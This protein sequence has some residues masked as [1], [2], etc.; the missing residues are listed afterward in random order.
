M[1]S[2]LEHIDDVGN[3]ARV[4]LSEIVDAY[5]NTGNPVS[6]KLISENL[7]SLL[8]PSTVRLIMSNL[9]ERGLLYSPHT[10]SGRI[11]TDKGLKFF[12]DGILE[13]GDL[14]SEEK[15]SLQAKCSVAENYNG[16]F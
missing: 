12:V 16:S 2:N 15:D 13:I 7:N 9:E 5:L 4:I 11:P 10:S 14:S 3:R 6:S 1:N 8:S